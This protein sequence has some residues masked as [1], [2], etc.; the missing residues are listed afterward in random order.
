MVYP[1]FDGT[2]GVMGLQAFLGW[3][4]LGDS[5]RVNVQEES[6]WKDEDFFFFAPLKLAPFERNELK[7]PFLKRQAGNTNSRTK[8][9]L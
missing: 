3:A 5:S 1:C 7:D 4:V 8:N 9:K 2:T 6:N